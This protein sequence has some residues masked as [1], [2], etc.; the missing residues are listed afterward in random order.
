MKKIIGMTVVC[1]ALVSVLLVGGCSKTETTTAAPRVIDLT[2]GA[3]SST[4]PYYA[5][6][7]SLASGIQKANPQFNITIMETGGSVDNAKR[8]RDEICEISSSNM[9]SD[10]ESYNGTGAF[11]GEPNKDIR[12]LWYD[13]VSVYQWAATRESGIR[14]L[15]DFDGKYVSPGGAGTQQALVSQEVYKLFGVTPRLFEG[16]QS[17]AG[18]AFQNR[19]IV[20]VAKLGPTPDSFLQ[21]MQATQNIIFIDVTQEEYEKILTI[22][23]FMN[24]LTIPAST[25]ETPTDWHSIAL[26]GGTETLSSMPQDVGYTLV[27]GL[28]VDARAEWM[29]AYPQGGSVDILGQTLQAKTPLHAGTVQYMVEKGYTVPPHLIPPEYVAVKE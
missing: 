3:S 13:H 1:L 7:A 5:F 25:Y 23:P 4:S 26:L 27:K 29:A 16:N 11:E 2:W 17:V 20:S 18:D 28:M 24:L 21:Q 15:K 12:V 8:L 9:Q 19:Q 22:Y 6:Y 10:M 14:S